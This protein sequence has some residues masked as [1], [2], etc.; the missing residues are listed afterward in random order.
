VA[1]V[2]ASRRASADALGSL[3]RPPLARVGVHNLACRI[4]ARFEDVRERLFESNPPAPPQIP[5]LPPGVYQAALIAGAVVLAT[6]RPLFIL[7]DD[8]GGAKWGGGG[9][10]TA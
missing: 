1:L 4:V 10:L 9:E 5:P 8:P 7:P 3:R 6:S 2:H